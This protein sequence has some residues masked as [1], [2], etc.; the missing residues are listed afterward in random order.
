MQVPRSKIC[1]IMVTILRSGVTFEID[2]E[3]SISEIIS[4]IKKRNI[5]KINPLYALNGNVTDF[6]IIVLVS[7]Y[8]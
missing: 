8:N 3:A 4:D 1:D 6:L 2:I 7:I 5:V